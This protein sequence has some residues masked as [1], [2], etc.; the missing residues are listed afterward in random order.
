M[1]T[2]LAK[3]G[4]VKK[5]TLFCRQHHDKNDW[6]FLPFSSTKVRESI[7]EMIRT[8]GMDVILSCDDES[9]EIQ[10]MLLAGLDQ[11]FMN[12]QWYAT[13]V[14]FVADKGGRELLRA[15]FKWSR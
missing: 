7:V 13:D 12:K 15:F 4:D 3:Y 5:L 11:F 6:N 9:G 14:H 2:R 1:A 10:G 8:D